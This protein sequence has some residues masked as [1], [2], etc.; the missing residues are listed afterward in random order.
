[1]KKYVKKPVY[2]FN[3]AYAEKLIM[4]LASDQKDPLFNRCKKGF[5]EEICKSKIVENEFEAAMLLELVY[6]ESTPN[7]E[8]TDSEI[9]KL[10]GYMVKR[11]NSLYE[12]GN[13]P[14]AWLM[15]APKI[16]KTLSKI[17][18]KYRKQCN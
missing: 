5:L 3:K 13:F 7:I 2:Y 8:S 11:I 14:S 12:K 4:R 15:Q 1:M 17:R 6:R 16:K 18:L 10:A 9:T